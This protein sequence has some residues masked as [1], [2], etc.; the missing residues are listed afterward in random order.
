VYDVESDRSRLVYSGSGYPPNPID[1]DGFYRIRTV[2]NLFYKE[3]IHIP[4]YT[5]MSAEKWD[6]LYERV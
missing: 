4:A 1:Y 2:R 3:E 6:E 5:F